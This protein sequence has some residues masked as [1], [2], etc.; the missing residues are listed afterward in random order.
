[1]TILNVRDVSKCYR[2]GRV[3]VPAVRNVSFSIADASFSVLTGPSGSGKT[4]LL[5]LI[6]CL[7]RPD[8]GSIE[9][10]GTQVGKLAEKAL[11]TF[12]RQHLGFVFQN[13]NLLAALTVAE[14]IAYPLQLAKQ[15]AAARK[16]RVAFLLDAVGLAGKEGRRPH[17]LSGGERQRVAIARALAARP[18]LVLADEPTASLD[19]ATGAQI[20]AL[21]RRLQR[22]QGVSF[23]FASHDTSLI[24]GADTVIH[25]RDG[26]LQT[27]ASGIDQ[28]VE[29]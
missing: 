26:V 20:V 14:N 13:F 2:L 1:M 11:T 3:P 17:E 25:L 5:N 16:E 15:D 29:A 22:E 6:G 19:R 28:L 9:I 18:R 27:R 21:M 10:A 4:S 24:A 7:D 12:R 23:L 8:S